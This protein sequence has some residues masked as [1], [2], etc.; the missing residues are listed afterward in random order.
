MSKRHSL[1]LT[2]MTALFM[3]YDSLHAQEVML[4][5]TYQGQPLTATY[6][7]S[8]KLD[9]IR[10]I[11]DGKALKTRNGSVIHAPQSFIDQLPSFS[12]EGELWAGRGQFGY[13]QQTV[14]DAKANQEAW[15]KVAFIMFDRIDLLSP[16]HMRHDDLQQ[17]KLNQ[18]SAFKQVSVIQQTPFASYVKL[19]RQLHKVVKLG[20]EGL[21]V[22]NASAVYIAGRSDSLYKIKTHQ[23]AEARV[24]GYTQGKGKYQALVGALLVESANGFRFS[25]GSG[26]SDELRRN[27]PKIGTNITYR[28]NDT[29]DNGIPKFARFVRVRADF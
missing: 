3:P 21:M 6:W 5:K 10:A 26:L 24:I 27:P 14:L 17:W 9:G 20:G 19:N 11:W 7:V 12:V 16:Y 13:V 2:V 1:S 18:G 29:T 4:A 23:D 22:R 15:S 28:Y 8:E 25:I